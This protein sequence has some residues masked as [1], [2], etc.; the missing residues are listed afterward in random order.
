MQINETVS[1]IGLRRA[2]DE[3]PQ[4]VGLKNRERSILFV[5]LKIRKINVLGSQGTA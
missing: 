3:I 2:V 5:A 1:E 4:V